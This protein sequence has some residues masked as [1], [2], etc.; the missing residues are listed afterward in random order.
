MRGDF[1]FSGLDYNGGFI[2]IPFAFS[3]RTS[4]L[5]F[6]SSLYFFFP[7]FFFCALWDFRPI[8]RAASFR[9]MYF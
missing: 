8:A 1:G 2:F 6:I 5:L 3:H 4:P 9:L 7:S